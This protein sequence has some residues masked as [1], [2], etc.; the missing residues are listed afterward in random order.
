MG[1]EKLSNLLKEGSSFIKF[2]SIIKLIPPVF[3]NLQWRFFQSPI[4]HIAIHYTG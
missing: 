2:Y 3:A 4:C 1:K